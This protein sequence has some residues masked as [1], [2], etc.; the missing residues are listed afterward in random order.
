MIP[1]SDDPFLYRKPAP[2][3]VLLCTLSVLLLLVQCNGTVPSS[4]SATP[5]SVVTQTVVRTTQPTEG[6]IVLTLWLPPQFD[7]NAKTPAAQAMADRLSAFLTANPDVK[8]DLRI[9]AV[10]GSSGLLETLQAASQVAPDSMPS[11]IAL[12][13]SQIEEAVAQDLILPLDGLTNVMDDKDWYSYAQNLA[14]L[15]GH[16]YGLPFAGDALLLMQRN[17]PTN[18]LQTTWSTLLESGQPILFAASD[19][20][21]SVTL[22]LYQSLGEPWIEN[23]G[24]PTVQPDTLTKVLEL[25]ASGGGNGTFPSW[26]SVYQSNNQ[27]WQAYQQGKSDRVIAWFSTGFADEENGN[28]EMLL[29]PSLGQISATLADGWV[30][31]LVE[32]NLERRAESIHLAEYLTSSE[33]LAAWGPSSGYLPTRP[34]TLSAWPASSQVMIKTIVS[35]VLVPPDGLAASLRQALEQ[36]TSLVILGQANPQ[37]AA[38]SSL[39]NP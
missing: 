19:P 6:P 38:K 12:N 28:L 17:I 26:L 24:H 10:S 3:L 25:Y 7:P 27:A 35:S 18:G 21:A 9:K 37:E 15:N 16:L 31:C 1:A 23:N 29:L 20:Q 30:L 39:L 22:A 8:I 13:R 11:L 5:T 32:P 34:S 36:A 33:A 2:G 14:T 4:I